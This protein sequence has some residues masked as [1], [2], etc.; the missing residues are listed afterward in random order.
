MNE[1]KNI[2][3]ASEV[4]EDAAARSVSEL[5]LG[6]ADETNAILSEQ[7]PAAQTLNEPLDANVKTLSPFMLVMKR[8]FR[9]RL[10]MVGLTLIILLFL[11]SFLGPVIFNR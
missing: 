1:E 9:S 6:N 11:F 10:S 8:F 3:A 2:R 7:A 5:T 4:I